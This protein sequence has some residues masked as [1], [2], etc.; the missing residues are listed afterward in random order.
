MKHQQLPDHRLLQ[1]TWVIALI[2]LLGVSGVSALEPQDM[3]S[4]FKQ[5]VQLSV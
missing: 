1:V 2:G 4:V 3:V 5:M